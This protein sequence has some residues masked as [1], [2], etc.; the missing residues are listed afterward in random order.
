MPRFIG[1][2]L[3]SLL[4]IVNRFHC[5]IHAVSHSQCGIVAREEDAVAGGEGARVMVGV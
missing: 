3:D 2:E 1:A 4:P 5:A